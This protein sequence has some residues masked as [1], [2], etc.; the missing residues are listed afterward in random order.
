MPN[1]RAVTALTK[2][3]FMLASGK[4]FNDRQVAFQTPSMMFAKTFT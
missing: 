2:P 4:K 3:L 1:A